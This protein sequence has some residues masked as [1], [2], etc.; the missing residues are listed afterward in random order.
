MNEDAEEHVAFYSW[1]A[2][3]ATT[4]H[5]VS[6]RTVFED[7]LKDKEKMVQLRDVLHVPTATNNLISISRL[8]E[9]G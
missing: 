9:Q 2:D 7:Y 5:I 1:V 3:T 4:S 6:Q 8:D